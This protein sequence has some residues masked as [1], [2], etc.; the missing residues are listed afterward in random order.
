MSPTFI[1]LHRENPAVGYVQA[2]DISHPRSVFIMYDVFMMKRCL[3][4]AAHLSFFSHMRRRTPPHHAHV[5][6]R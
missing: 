2:Y 1:P 4:A 5:R 3:I 6:Q